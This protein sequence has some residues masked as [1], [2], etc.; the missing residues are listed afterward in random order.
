MPDFMEDD[1]LVQV[2]MG[3][4]LDKFY[5][6][7]EWESHRQEMIAAKEGY[8]MDFDSDDHL[9]QTNSFMAE[10]VRF[11]DDEEVQVDDKFLTDEEWRAE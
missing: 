6:S 1:H 4:S 11:I 5:T 2:G 9:L 3:N 10:G 8:E 7:E